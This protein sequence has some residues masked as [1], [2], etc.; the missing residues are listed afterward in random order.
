MFPNLAILTPTWETAP[1]PTV[2]YILVGSGISKGPA[3]RGGIGQVSVTGDFKY[4]NLKL[5]SLCSSLS[6]S[7]FTSW[8]K[9]SQSVSVGLCTFARENI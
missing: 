7:S 5:I 8:E 4:S 9:G 2:P 3:S 1:D 6:K